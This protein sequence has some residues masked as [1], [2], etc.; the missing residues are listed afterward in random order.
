MKYIKN[1]ST[2]PYFNL[3]AEE[4]VLNSF[5]D[6]DYILLWQNDMTA[7]IGKHQNAAEE[8]NAKR[9]EELGVKVVRR[10]T[11]G[12]AVYH[13]MGNLNFS[14]ITDW[15]PEKNM[16]YDTFLK[17]VVHALFKF[18]VKAEKQG[19]NDLVVDGRKISGNAQCI[20][21]GRILHHGTLLVNSDLSMMPEILNVQ[22]D[23]IESKG[24]KS[25]RSRVAN[26]CE[27][28]KNPIDVALLKKALAESF[29]EGGVIE[30]RTLDEAQITEI[31]KLAREKY[32]TWEWNYGSFAGYAFKSSKRFPGGKVEVHLD[33]KNGLIKRCKIFGDF[34]ALISVEEIENAVMGCRADR[35]ELRETLRGFELKRY[36]GIELDELLECFE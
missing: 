2:N 31:E 8:V 22:T 14:F 24:I 9:A 17:P 4:Y 6:D 30:E 16:D 19:R 11:G 20:H 23:K 7:V 21:R 36:Y 10:N 32:E 35:T 12:G 33:V 15:D 27:F 1:D 26:I 28:T 5:R 18:G 13:D 25:V 29:F 34:L 3:A